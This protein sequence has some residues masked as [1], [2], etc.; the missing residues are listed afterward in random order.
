MFKTILI[1][2]LFLVLIGCRNE[3]SN[4]IKSENCPVNTLK[5]FKN[6]HTKDGADISAFPQMDSVPDIFYQTKK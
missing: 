3:E 6:H 5:Y 2:L 4:N 1:N